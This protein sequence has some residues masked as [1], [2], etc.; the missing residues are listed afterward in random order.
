MYVHFG[1]VD[2]HCFID[3][4]KDENLACREGN[5]VYC[6]DV[7]DESEGACSG[8]ED[9]KSIFTKSKW[10]LLSGS[11]ANI[12][13]YS[14]H[15]SIKNLR[16]VTRGV[17]NKYNA[18]KIISTVSAGLN[19]TLK[20]LFRMPMAT[21]SY[22]KSSENIANSGFMLRS[23]ATGT[24]YLMLNMFVNAKGNLEAQI[25]TDAGSGLNGELE[26][27]GMPISV[28]TASMVMM[29]ATLNLENKLV[30]S[31]F[32][33][34]NY[35]GSPSEYK[36]TFNLAGLSTS[37]ADRAHEYVGFS[38]A[39]PNFKLYGIEMPFLVKCFCIAFKYFIYINQFLV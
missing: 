17:N 31:A 20:A 3:E 15:I 28:S 38:L 1:E 2:K 29:S 36:V 30:I 23:D 9:S 22:G 35:Y 37:Y 5:V 34:N 8:V 25:W 16:K 14:G 21:S 12:E 19:G 27:N 13:S 39:D 33:G 6:I 7:C 26:Q 11:L 32:T 10:H 24:E 18:I 4:F